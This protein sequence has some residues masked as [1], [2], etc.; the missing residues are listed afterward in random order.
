MTDLKNLFFS[1]L[2]T[3]LLQSCLTTNERYDKLTPGIWRGELFLDETNP[4]SKNIS[5]VGNDQDISFKN[6]FTEGVLPFNF[7]VSYGNGDSLIIDFINGDQKTRAE[8]IL[9]G[10]DK[11]TAKDTIRINFVA[12]DTY[13][14]AEIEDGMMTG[15][16]YNPRKN[17][18]IPFRGLAAKAHRFTLL[19]ETPVQNITGKW[20]TKFI[21]ESD[22]SEAIG[23]FDVKGNNVT[24]T[25]AS[26]TGDYGYLEG[27]V[28]GDKVYLSNFDGGHAYL[29]A[30]KIIDKNNLKGTFYSGKT[31][32]A[33]WSAMRDDQAV[34]PDATKMVSGYSSDPV[35]FSFPNEKGELISLNDKKF[36]GKAKVITLMGTWC[37]NCKDESNFLTE[38]K[39]QHPDQNF[40]IIALA[41]EAYDD[42]EKVS[43]LLT[44]YKRV[45][46]IEYDVLWAGKVGKDAVKNIPFLNE[47]KAYPTMIFLNKDNQIVKVHTGFSG[48]ATKEYAGFKKE[49][50]EEIEK[51]TKA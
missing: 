36:E 23:Q 38:Y 46:N 40:E 49:F 45:L 31:H 30:G 2:I 8:E 15:A 41:F 20:P 16:W 42:K 43:R 27:T 5:K 47:I 35:K 6:A 26:A 32:R 37:P 39:K 4:L 25:F 50:V 33:T 51:L 29:F 28:Q 14:R 44:N 9:Y 18:R 11:R 7:E 3:L 12:F 22:T 34:L 21:S 48:P 24:G 1:L 17:Y 19:T 13:I 10:R